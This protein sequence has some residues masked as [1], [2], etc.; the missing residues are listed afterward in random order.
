[1]LELIT[2]KPGNGKTLYMIRRAHKEYVQ[3]DPPRPVYYYNISG[4]TLEGFHE[5]QDPHE[6][7][8]CPTGSLIIIDEVHKVWP[9]RQKGDPPA[10]AVELAEHRHYGIDLLVAT[11]DPADLDI[12]ARRRC[13]RHRHFVR[14]FEAGHARHFEWQ[15]VVMDPYDRF[16]QKKAVE[17]T[18]KLDPS[19]FGTYQSTAQDTHKRKLPWKKLAPVGAAAVVALVLVAWVINSISGWGDVG[20]NAANVDVANQAATRAADAADLASRAAASAAASVEAIR[21]QFEEAV[22]GLPWSAPFYGDLV[23]PKTLPVVTGCIHIDVGGF[24]RCE[25][26]DQH[27]EPVKVSVPQCLDYV[28]NGFP[29]DWSGERQA[30][31]AAERQRLNA[32]KGGG[33]GSVTS[34]G[35]TNGSASGGAPAP[36]LG[37]GA[38]AASSSGDGFPF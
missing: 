21:Q 10:S 25:C 7:M 36:S 5:L 1:M 3:A 24:R 38:R 22:E 15:N 19:Y 16:E 32:A 12:F 26:T 2:G 35:S 17:H 20:K 37:G 23:R 33:V 8:K 14:P 29:F 6:W 11:Q 4:V 30:A 34:S 28:N 27:G 31:L 9:Q 13:G 18:F